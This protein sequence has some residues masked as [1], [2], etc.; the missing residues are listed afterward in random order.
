MK[1][2]REEKEDVD[3]VGLFE[4]QEINQFQDLWP[5]FF[6]CED[7]EDCDLAALFAYQEICDKHDLAALFA[8]QEIDDDSGLEGLF[9]KACS[10]PSSDS[11]LPDLQTPVLL[12]NVVSLFDSGHVER[13]LLPTT[14]L[15]KSKTPP[16]RL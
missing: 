7:K 13:V 14:L 12:L 11:D 9:D 16:G 4:T 8:V 1:I 3:L 5:F 15:P 2:L 10:E 6:E